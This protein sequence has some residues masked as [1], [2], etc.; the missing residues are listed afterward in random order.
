MFQHFQSRPLRYCLS[1]MLLLMLFMFSLDIHLSMAQEPSILEKIQARITGPFHFRL[2]LQPLLAI[3][4][5]IRDGRL[6][7]KNKKPAFLLHLITSQNDRKD[8]LKQI[9]PAISKPL[10]IGII[11]DMVVQ[12]MIFQSVRIWGAI[13]LGAIIIALPYSLSRGLSNRYFR[14][15]D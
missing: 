3:V 12:F 15:K 4:L 2:I 13:L 9:W 6:D 10:V 7:A 14:K 5:G 1:R 8:Y 11:L